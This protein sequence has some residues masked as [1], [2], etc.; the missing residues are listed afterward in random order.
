MA[1]G[2]ILIDIKATE[3]VSDSLNKVKNDAEGLK[4]SVSGADKGLSSMASSLKSFAKL[5]A[6]TLLT[7]QLV[8]FGKSCVEAYGRMEQLSGGVQ[9]LFGKDAQRVLDN[10]NKAFSTAQ[11]S[12][13]QYLETATNFSA[14]LIN[15]LE[16]N[17][18][19]ATKYIDKAMIQMSDNANTFGT[20]MDEVQKAY[21]SMARGNYAMLDSLKLGYGG[22]KKEMERLL[23]DAEKLSGKDFE[24]GNF[25]DLIDAIQVVQDNLNVT[26]KTA[27]ESA[28]TIEGSINM[29]KATWD[30]FKVAVASGVGLD[31]ATSNLANSLT[32][33][34][35]NV[36]PVVGQIAESLTIE[37]GKQ[38]ATADWGKIGKTITDGLR[39]LGEPIARGFAE[40]I[41]NAFTKSLENTMIGNKSLYE[42]LVGDKSEAE[43]VANEFMTDLSKEFSKAGGQWNDITRSLNQQLTDALTKAT[44]NGDYSQAKDILTQ[45]NNELRSQGSK[46][47]FEIDAEGKLVVTNTTELKKDSAKKLKEIIG[48]K[49]TSDP[50]TIEQAVDFYLKAK[51]DGKGTDVVNQYLKDQGFTQEQVVDIMVS[52]NVELARVNGDVGKLT[53]DQLAEKY[54]MGSVE[55]TEKAVVTMTAEYVI[56]EGMSYDD[57][58]SFYQQQGYDKQSIDQIEQ[59]VQVMVEGTVNDNLTPTVEQSNERIHNTLDSFAKNESVDKTVTANANAQVETGQAL[60]TMESGQAKLEAQGTKWK[61]PLNLGVKKVS[62]SSLANINTSGAISSIQSAFGRITSFWNSLKVNLGNKSVTG[63]ITATIRTTMNQI[64][65]VSKKEASKGLNSLKGFTG[66]FGKRLTAGVSDLFSGTTTISGSDGLV[67]YVKSLVKAYH[68][69]EQTIQDSADKLTKITEEAI[70]D[71]SRKLAEGYTEL[72]EFDKRASEREKKKADLDLQEAE[73]KLNTGKTDIENQR[74]QLAYEEAKDRV[75]QLS[76]A[77]KE[78][79]KSQEEEQDKQDKLKQ[80]QEKIT[81][82]YKNAEEQLANLKKQYT[83]DSKDYLKYSDLS[84]NYN[85]QNKN[86]KALEKLPGL[87]DS[88]RAKGMP[89]ALIQQLLNMSPTEAVALAEKYNRMKDKQFSNYMDLW[90]RSENASSL[91]GK[92]NV[93]TDGTT[94][95]YQE[96]VRELLT[97]IKN[98]M[99]D[100]YGFTREQV[101]LDVKLNWSTM[102]GGELA[103]LLLPMIEA[104]AL[105]L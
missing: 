83:K 24:M 102:T 103:K 77:Y 9:Q 93:D 40:S 16:G 80:Q 25:A 8:D 98:E 37:L 11:M 67:N 19:L 79:V 52:A 94:A 66:G 27:L 26:G 88:L 21:Q 61:N 53:A 87:L 82:V 43:T 38:L 30:N 76:D 90:T 54:K 73:S 13:N 68:D 105:R 92:I 31:E 33:V 60:A 62:G 39:D 15:D 55:L 48:E 95:K 32:T 59:Q 17:T 84:D 46:T 56:G 7:K 91:L 36:A 6:V 1:D 75:Y 34:I 51:A 71:V 65:T 10:A 5:T 29:M 50:V 47:Q 12:A 22:T 69:V 20:T 57:R 45:L 2:S 18:T 78:L 81:E 96:D 86:V 35:Q 44:K 28:T 4:S 104:E 70:D 23:E 99:M 42:L 100:T 64:V 74:Y 85:A 58:M 49:G 14:K 101:G 41:G 3:N 63:S 97:D 89:D 72:T